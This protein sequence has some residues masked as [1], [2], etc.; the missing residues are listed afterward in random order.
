MLTHLRYVKDG[1]HRYYTMTH[2][3]QPKKADEPKI[4]KSTPQLT[5]ESTP[6][7]F[8][9]CTQLSADDTI[10]CREPKIAKNRKARNNGNLDAEST[11]LAPPDSEDEELRLRGFEPLTFG[12]VDRCSI[13]LSHRRS[14][15]EFTALGGTCQLFLKNNGS[16]KSKV[17]ISLPSCRGRRAAE[18]SPAFLQGPDN[19]PDPSC[20]PL[21]PNDLAARSEKKRHFFRKRRCA[22]ASLRH[23]YCEHQRNKQL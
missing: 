21:S 6:T 23:L 11:E 5:P 7:A 10:K 9:A 12:S 15:G 17:G 22:V 13:Q 3:A 18:P 4:Q 20:Y 1:S 8:P 14:M 2:S 19:T 16:T